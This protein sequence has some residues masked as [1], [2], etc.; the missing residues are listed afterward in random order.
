MKKKVQSQ[1]IDHL[2]ILAGVIKDLGIIEKIDARIPKDPRQ[3]LSAGESIAGMIINALGFSDRP[4]S[5]TPQF[6]ENKALEKFFRKGVTSD[7]FNRFKLG[8]VLD[9]CYDY[10]CDTLFSE[11]SLQVC[12]QEQIETRL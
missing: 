6:Y 3:T 2:G 9:A 11:L 5:L 7:Q 10:G 12:K 1:R 4:I 8:R